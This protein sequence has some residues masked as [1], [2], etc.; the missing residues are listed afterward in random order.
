[1]A[2]IELRQRFNEALASAKTNPAPAIKMGSAFVMASSAPWPKE[3]LLY[4]LR[5]TF[6]TRLAESGARE[7]EIKALMG[8]SSVRVSEKYIHVPGE[9]LSLAMK[10][11]EAYGKMLRGE[12]M[13]HE[14]APETVRE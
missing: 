3:F 8:H 4:S 1:M 12:T 2:H 9:H 5:H 11:A 13:Q 14:Q 7:F 6:G 10:R